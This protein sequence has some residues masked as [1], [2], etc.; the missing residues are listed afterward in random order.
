[1]KDAV[2]Q[3]I[4]SYGFDW[5]RDREAFY[6]TVG[7]AVR[8]YREATGI[9]KPGSQTAAEASGTWRPAERT[10]G[11]RLGD[12]GTRHAPVGDG[13]DVRRRGRAALMSA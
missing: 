10:P 5:L 2:R 3:N 11:R 4:E 13:R 9:A 1:M 7:K 6:P 8:A 12:A